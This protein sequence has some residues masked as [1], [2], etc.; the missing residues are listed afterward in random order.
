MVE[1]D[2]KIIPKNSGEY[3]GPLALSSR[4]IVAASRSRAASIIG[5]RPSKSYVE[6][7][8]PGANVIKL[9]AAVIYEFYY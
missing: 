9:F 4:L 5:S 3:V 8:Q 7:L 6:I 2:K 1:S